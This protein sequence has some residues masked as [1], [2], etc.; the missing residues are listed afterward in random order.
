MMWQKSLVGEHLGI[1]L[2]LLKSCEKVLTSHD[3]P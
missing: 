3:S 1:D 2:F